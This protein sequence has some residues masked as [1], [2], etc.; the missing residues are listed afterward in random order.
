MIAF[1]LLVIVVGSANVLSLPVNRRLP[2]FVFLGSLAGLLLAANLIP[3][4]GVVVTAKGIV[5]A[6]YLLVLIG[7]PHRLAGISRAEA[8]F[9]R[10][11]RSILG[12]V[13]KS[14]ARWG[15]AW[16]AR[17]SHDPAAAQLDV[18]KV[19]EGALADLANVTPPSPAWANT[20]DR[21]R[22]YLTAVAN[23]AA[24]EV[25]D[26]AVRPP[27]DAAMQRLFGELNSSWDGA[28]GIKSSKSRFPSDRRA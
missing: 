28:L 23:R 7:F 20:V 8:D 16:K 12:R 4:P 25:A 9:Y 22:G 15:R 13:Q 6:T 11:L 18:K 3:N 19:A 1:D 21:L 14:Q 10:S 26:G 17:L 5:I 24:G 2:A 27:D